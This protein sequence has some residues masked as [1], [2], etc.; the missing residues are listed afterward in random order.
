MFELV[1]RTDPTLADTLHDGSAYVTDGV[2]R[3]IDTDA[4]VT[5]GGIY[6]IV[7]SARRSEPDRRDP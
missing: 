2:G 1:T 3:K 4:P 5:V 7:I 6:R